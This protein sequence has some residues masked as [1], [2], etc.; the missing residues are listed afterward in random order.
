MIAQYPDFS[1]ISMALR[2]VLHPRF[3]TLAGGISEFTFA[4]IYLFRERHNY[5]ISQLTDGL[6]VIAG[7]DGAEPFFMLP[8]GLPVEGILRDLFGRYR[9]A[10]ALSEP[11]AEKVAGLGYRILQDR[12]NFD[13][14]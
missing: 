6:F 2:P 14:L 7:R 10:K 12:D 3:K 11:Q 9:L 8:F 13:Y 5:R 1:E 4:N